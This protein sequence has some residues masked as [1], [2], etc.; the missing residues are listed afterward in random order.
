MIKLGNYPLKK[1]MKKNRYIIAYAAFG[2]LLGSIS[3]IISYVFCNYFLLK[4]E[5]SATIVSLHQKFPLLYVIDTAPLVISLTACFLWWKFNSLH[6]SYQKDIQKRNDSLEIANKNLTLLNSEKES[7]LKEIHH[8]VKN[9]LQIIT[10]LLSLQSGFIEDKATKMLFRY[11]QYR[12]NS[13]A[14][15]H[16][17][18][19]RSNNISKIDFKDYTNKIVAGLIVSMKGNNNNVQLRIAIE[20]VYL[21]MDTAIPLGLLINEI[22]TNALKYGIQGGSHGVIHIEIKNTRLNHFRMLIGDNGTGFRDDITF[23]NPNSLGLMLIHKL[24]L[25]LKGSIEKING[26][27]GTN[28]MI[29]FQEIEST[30]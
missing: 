9:N 4:P 25:Q 29:I 15:I 6:K 3:P 14:M 1:P 17:S 18:L 7:L 22:I 11:S 5:E 28:Y 2:L 20:D 23:R 24:S 12:I 10:S 16:D 27:T 13:L 19:Y 26:T 30:Y 8:R 21:N